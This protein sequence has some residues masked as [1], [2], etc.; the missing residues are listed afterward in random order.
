[1]RSHCRVRQTVHFTSPKALLLPDTRSYFARLAD[2]FRHSAFR[3][4]WAGQLVNVI[5][6]AV[7]G[8]AIAFHVLP[9]PDAARALAFILGATSV[10]VLVSLLVG[11]VLADRHRR[12]RVI[13]AA[14]LVRAV[15]LGGILL[16]GRSGSLWLLTAC[17]GL[18]GVGSG[19]YRPAYSALLPSVLPPELLAAANALRA[20]TNRMAGIVGAAL[21]G[22]M[23]AAT[24]PRV[25]LWIDF[26]TF[27]VS[28]ATLFG[29]DDAAP[30]GTSRRSLVADAR[31]GIAHV[32]ER[33]WMAAVMAQGTFQVALAVAPMMVLL[34]LLLGGEGSSWYGIVV[35]AEAAGAIAGASLGAV[36][37]IAL[38]ALVPQIVGVA[39]EAPAWA[40]ALLSLVAGVG[41]S[42]FA[43]L[44]LTALQ[45]KVPREMVGRVLSIDMLA[46]Q[47]FMP[48]GL[49]L[50]GWLLPSWGTGALAWGAVAV[51]VVSTVAVLP[52]PGVL[53]F[54]DPESPA[55]A[56][57]SSDP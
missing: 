53:E 50:T 2:P 37:I 46:T 14:D 39:L 30:V 32:L 56:S 21:A 17:A 38:L 3:L 44:W 31:A 27:F 57:I 24:S 29:I 20:L 36:A 55:P 34:P 26:G 47:S 41:H 22:V 16:V 51:M 10:G 19:M 48:L 54:A 7:Y 35:A 18:L 8:V 52:V 9:R 6:D 49:V 11:G 4:A 43:V 33:P 1:M 28:I 15:G 23:I 13:I 42:V 45:T 40:L 12:S 25:T 5:G